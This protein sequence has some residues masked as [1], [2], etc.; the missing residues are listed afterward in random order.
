Y[1]K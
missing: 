1:L